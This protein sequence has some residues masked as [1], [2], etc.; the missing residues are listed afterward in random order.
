MKQ[1]GMRGGASEKERPP[2]SR[3]LI[4][5]EARK[6]TKGRG[7]GGWGLRARH[8]EKAEGGVNLVFEEE[9]GKN[10]GRSRWGDRT[11]QPLRGRERDS[12]TPPAG[13]RIQRSPGIWVENE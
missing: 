7:G 1:R 10:K 8:G 2:A 13:K 9:E 6:E 12:E 11:S 4:L 5:K 3:V